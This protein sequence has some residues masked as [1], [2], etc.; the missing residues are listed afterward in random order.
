MTN[1]F[2]ILCKHIQTTG[3]N[4]EKGIFEHYCPIKK[5]PVEIITPSCENFEKQ[6]KRDD[7]EVVEI[8]IGE[9]SLIHKIIS[10]I[11]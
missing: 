10:K 9:G 2:C 4:N 6:E 3:F 1:N 5:K 8:T 11:L 7:F